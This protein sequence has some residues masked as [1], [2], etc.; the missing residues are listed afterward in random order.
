MREGGA[1]TDREL[2]APLDPVKK[3]YFRILP[4]H[5]VPEGA[6][7]SREGVRREGERGKVGS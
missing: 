6:R 4:N 2:F 5:V 1:F 7:Y 3:K